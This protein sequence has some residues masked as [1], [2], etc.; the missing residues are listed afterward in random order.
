VVAVEGFEG[1][2][3]VEGGVVPENGA[4]AGW[5]VEVRGFVEDFGGVGEDEEAVGKAFGDPEELEI[6]VW[7]LGFQMESG[8]F[9]EVRGVAAKI[10]GDVPDVTGEDANEFALGPGELVM[11]PAED[12][13]AGEGLVV[14]N[15]LGGKTG[16]GK[17]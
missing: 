3:D 17:R 11:Q 7:R 14:L 16:G 9:S 4:F 10:D 1:P 6:V 2:G 15:K 5:M 8:P 12:A 13:F